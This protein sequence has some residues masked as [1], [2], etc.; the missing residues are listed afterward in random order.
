MLGRL[1]LD[2]L[3]D[4]AGAVE[5]FSFAMAHPGAGF[6]LEDAEARRIEALAKSRRMLE[7]RAARDQFLARHAG[8]DRA[9]FVAKL[10][11]AP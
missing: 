8:S 1:R 10:C 4:A 3:G 9:A 7:C 11:G 6:F 5:P 2:A